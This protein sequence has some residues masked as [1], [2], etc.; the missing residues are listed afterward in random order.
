MTKMLIMFFAVAAMVSSTDLLQ[1][2]GVALSVAGT[3][4]VAVYAQRATQR[5][6]KAVQ[7][8]KDNEAKAAQA[9]EE[10]ER[11]EKERN[12]SRQI[13]AE[14]FNRARESY[15]RTIANTNADLERTHT[16]LAEVRMENQAL[17]ARVDTL[18]RVL[19]VNGLSVPAIEV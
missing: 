5:T 13:E 11:L 3:I 12:A 1:F 10:K 14:A 9:R 16:E 7:E 8:Q 17:R 6:Q 15:E 18:E 2:F 4:F 19:R